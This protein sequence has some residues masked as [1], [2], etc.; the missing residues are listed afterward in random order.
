MGSSVG[1]KCQTPTQRRI[2][3]TGG[4]CGDYSLTLRCAWLQ[5]QGNEGM[6]RGRS[7]M[8]KG[9]LPLARTFAGTGVETLWFHLFF[10]R[11]NVRYLIGG[12]VKR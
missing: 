1:D 5:V 9:P 2:S 6:I 8:L 11:R 7:H 3:V 12:G 10:S 4:N